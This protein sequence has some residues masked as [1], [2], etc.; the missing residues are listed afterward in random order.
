MSGNTSHAANRSDAAI[1]AEA[2]K[3]LDNCPTVPGTVRVHVED[4]LVTLTGSVQRP[5]QRTDAE[6]V[7]R[8]VIGGRHLVNNITVIP[9]PSTEWFDA[10]DDRS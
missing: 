3:G 8:P 2:R 10:P 7:V 4:G 1:F 6:H 5:S 9:A